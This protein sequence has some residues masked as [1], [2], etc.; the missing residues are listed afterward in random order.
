MLSDNPAM[1]MI[2]IYEAKKQVSKLV[3]RPAAGEHVIIARSG[4]PVAH[5][6]RLEVAP[7]GELSLLRAAPPD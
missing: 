5:L 2:N 6:S 7:R 3:E 1:T 4:K